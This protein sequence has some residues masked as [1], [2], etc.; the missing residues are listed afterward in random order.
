[1]C[2]VPFAG[3]QHLQFGYVAIVVH[4]QCLANTICMYAKTHPKVMRF[5][6][7]TT[8]LLYTFTFTFSM[9]CITIP[10]VLQSYKVR[11]TG[12]SDILLK[13]SKAYAIHVF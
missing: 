2:F 5:F 12:L 10:K 4:V 11:Q 7:I 1:M 8:V 9:E 6:E 3:S 13:F